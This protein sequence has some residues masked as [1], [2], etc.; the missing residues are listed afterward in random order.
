M[1]N[2]S[3]LATAWQLQA[4][5]YFALERNADAVRC[6]RFAAGFCRGTGRDGRL[7]GWANAIAEK[8]P[9]FTF[10]EGDEGFEDVEE[11][12]W[13]LYE[14]SCRH[15]LDNCTRRGLDQIEYTLESLA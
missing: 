13:D 11:R 4:F 1:T 9:G 8:A 3:A 12:Y 14:D 10:R 6:L 2:G 15:D 5:N 7:L